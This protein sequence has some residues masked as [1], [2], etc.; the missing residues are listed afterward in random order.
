[1]NLDGY[2]CD[3][4]WTKIAPPPKTVAKKKKTYLLIYSNNEEIIIDDH[5][6]DSCSLVHIVDKV[7]SARLSPEHCNSLSY[8]GISSDSNTD[9]SPAPSS[10]QRPC[11]CSLPNS[12][13]TSKVSSQ[14]QGHDQRVVN[15]LSS[16][17]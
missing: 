13:E 6:L 8:H 5:S 12:G 10:S 9:R 16:D 4:D 3:F 7:Y 2:D 11:Q 15:P 14:P 1:M 17:S